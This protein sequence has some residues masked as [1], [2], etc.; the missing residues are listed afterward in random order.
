MFTKISC[1][2]LMLTVVTAVSSITAVSGQDSG[3]LRNLKPK[4]T[5]RRVQPKSGTIVVHD[6]R[7][8]KPSGTTIPGG[9]KV[10]PPRRQPTSGSRRISVSELRNRLQALNN[11]QQPQ[12]RK[13]VI[14]PTP[15]NNPQLKSICDQYQDLIDLIDREY[16][17]AI[18]SGSEAEAE[19]Y[20]QLSIRAQS[21]ARRHGCRGVYLRPTRP[22][23]LVID[24]FKVLKVRK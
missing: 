23:G 21:D 17:R 24:K 11:S 5:V 16:G 1:A 13:A 9:V 10:P 6:H 4:V 18:Q 22:G 20:Y 8:E 19:T 12:S 15:E 3:S 7:G 14:K 2:M